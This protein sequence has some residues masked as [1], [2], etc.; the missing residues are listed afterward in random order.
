MPWVLLWAVPGEVLNC[1]SKAGNRDFLDRL[2]LFFL[3]TPSRVDV[4]ILHNLGLVLLSKK[5]TIVPFVGE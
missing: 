4:E 3:V 1:L 2:I 5:E